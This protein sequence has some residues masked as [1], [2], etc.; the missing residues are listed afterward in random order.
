MTK[1]YETA[2]Y[3]L[4][5]LKLSSDY[6]EMIDRYYLCANKKHNYTSGQLFSTITY[7]MMLNDYVG[8]INE[9]IIDVK[10]LKNTV[11][12]LE[13]NAKS[14]LEMSLQKELKK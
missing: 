14:T 5:N 4:S 1:I 8:E 2:S 6:V 3:I 11:S 9:A 12:R 10:D 13:R 7:V